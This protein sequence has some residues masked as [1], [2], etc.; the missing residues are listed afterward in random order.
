MP[1]TVNNARG[2]GAPGEL[3][4]SDAWG[5]PTRDTPSAKRE[6][7]ERHRCSWQ[8]RKISGRKIRD[9]HVL[10]PV[11]QGVGGLSPSTP[12]Y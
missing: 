8:T 5:T 1:H 9:E 11:I 7:G 10:R 3:D 12:P 4:R 6:V 2:G